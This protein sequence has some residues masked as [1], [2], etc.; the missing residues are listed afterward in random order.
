M[1]E[2]LVTR[3]GSSDSNRNLALIVSAVPNSYIAR[4][5][6]S[7]SSETV[8]S[9]YSVLFKIGDASS[10]SGTVAAFVQLTFGSGARI[11]CAFFLSEFDKEIEGDGFTVKMSRSTSGDEIMVY[12]KKSGSSFTGNVSIVSDRLIRVI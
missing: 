1:G 12:A 10:R 2:A 3:R 4:F 9:D 7:L 6:T 8:S 5:T 11:S